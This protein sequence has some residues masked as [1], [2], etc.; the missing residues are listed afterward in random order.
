M[1]NADIQEGQTYLFIGSES[2]KRA[3][4]AGEPFTV[5]RIE[6]VYRKVRYRAGKR[7]AKVLRFFNDDGIGARGDELEPLP[8]EGSEDWKDMSEEPPCEGMYMVLTERKAYLRTKWVV[9]PY[10]PGRFG[11]WEYDQ[12]Q[13]VDR[14]EGMRGPDR[15]EKWLAEKMKICSKCRQ[16]VPIT[17]FPTVGSAICNICEK[18]DLTF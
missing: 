16:A 3:H 15:V 5:A 17:S 11:Y 9:E 4:L 12:E 14:E 10:T 2:P 7:S 18:P 8:G 13:L 1:L 6:R